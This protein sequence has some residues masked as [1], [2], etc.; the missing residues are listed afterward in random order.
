MSNLY[1]LSPQD[2]RRKKVASSDERPVLTHAC[3]EKHLENGRTAHS[4]STKDSVD[5][6]E[7]YADSRQVSSTSNN[8]P[9]PSKSK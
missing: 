3:R 2:N 4:T 1:A 7:E 5:E 9:D 8:P 6:C